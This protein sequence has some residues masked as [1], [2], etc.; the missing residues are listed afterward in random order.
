M[1]DLEIRGAGNMLGA[2]QSGQIHAV[3]MELYGQL[4]QEAVNELMLSEGGE[5][6][7]TSDR[8]QLPRI[9]L[10]LAASIPDD[11]V[12]HMPTR[13]AIYQKLAKVSSQ[14]QV[15]EIS[16]EL[17]DRFGPLPEKTQNLLT[18]T[19]IR[20]VAFNVDADS[21]SYRNNTITLNF[22]NAV[23]SARTP[24]QRALGPS[25]KVGNQQLQVSVKGSDEEAVTRFSLILDRLQVFLK[26]LNSM[27][28][29]D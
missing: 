11:Y 5:V 29:Q 18:L 15:W 2:A 17:K 28:A 1:R 23:G 26:A 4:L 24:L 7:T 13:M 19:R 22:K 10:P 25:V 14:D 12:E 16:E 27:A 3:G 6:A 20:S 8:P 9:D 21:V